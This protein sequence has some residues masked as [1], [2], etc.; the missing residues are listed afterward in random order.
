MKKILLSFLCCMLAVIGMQAAEVS[1]TITF[2]T[3]GSDSSSPATSANF[4]TGQITSSDFDLTCTATNNCYTGKSGLKLSSSSKNGSF[5][6][7]FSETL[8]VKSVTV[9]A[10]R[11]KSTEAATVTVNS[12]T[13]QSLT[14]TMAD[15]VFDVNSEINAIKVDVTKRVYIESITVTYDDGQGGGEGGETPDPVDVA[16]PTFTP[17]D[18]TTFEES[19]DVTINVEDGLTAWYTTEENG[20]YTQGNALTIDATTTVWA[21]AVDAEGNE[22]DVVTATYTLLAPPPAGESITNKYIFSDYAIGTQYAQGEEHKLDNDV[23]LTINGAQL[24]TQ[25]RLYAGSNAV[26]E[27][28]NGVAT[29]IILK[30]GYK[31]ATLTINGSND[32]S[33]WTQIA[34]QATTTTYTEYTFVVP[35]YKYV[36]MVSAGA[37]I[38]VSEMTLTYVVDAEA[39]NVA[40]PTFSVPAGEVEQGTVVTINVEDGLTAYYS[41]TGEEGSYVAGNQV[42]INEATTIYAYAQ[43]AEENKS[44]VVSAQYTIFI[45]VEGTW[46]L[47]TDAN[48]L[49]NGDEVVIVAKE[50]NVALSTDA[51]NY[52][53][54]AAVKKEGNDVKFTQDV[55]VITL[56]EVGEANGVRTWS[57]QT[58]E[59]YLYSPGTSNY[60]KTDADNN[61]A[62]SI[63]IGDEAAGYAAGIID[64]NNDAAE[65]ANVIRYNQ[66]NVRFSCYKA[67]NS[68]YDIVMYRKVREANIAATMYYL[69]PGVWETPDAPW[70]AAYF[71]NQNNGTAEW[72]RGFLSEHIVYFDLEAAGSFT[73]ITFCRMNPAYQEMT[74]DDAPVTRSSDPEARIWDKVTVAYTGENPV[75]SI[76]DEAWT[77]VATGIEGVVAANGIA[78]ANGIVAA[79]GAIEVYNVNGMVV[80]R[81]NESLDLRNLNAGVY[82][83]R[84]GNNVR[85]VVR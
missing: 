58:A 55:Q 64:M 14:E 47:V 48:T 3:S 12:V 9:R 25:V 41:L 18:G 80:A 36:Q 66:S 85:K 31:A 45:P 21:K 29:E 83:V 84:N 50:Q 79:E 81:G 38:R 67:E 23:T 70:Y 68:Q 15:Y 34:T 40:E 76:D 82:I 2:K 59:G 75:Y 27:V 32:G 52:R 22:S 74:F 16:E 43:D 17:A 72:V 51:G 63:A 4:V 30:A 44:D 62:W 42:T 46:T 65:P 1:G 61:A 20:E 78:Y 33:T 11:W 57:M 73:H 10:M 35:N 54:Q 71:Y 77:S 24:N 28:N 56:G 19:L 39:V 69:L 37:Q 8:N 13:A 60:L 26:V 49:C 6:L 53:D 7:Q 5:T